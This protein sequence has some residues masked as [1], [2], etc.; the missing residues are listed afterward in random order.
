MLD[1]TRAFRLQ[2]ALRAPDA[3]RTTDRALLQRLRTLDRDAVARVA[4]RHLACVEID[5]LLERRDLIVEW[6]DALV[7]QR[8]AA[9]VL[10]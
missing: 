10:F 8:G 1:C 7:Q 9:A 3:L 6:F 2:P 5:A 4:G